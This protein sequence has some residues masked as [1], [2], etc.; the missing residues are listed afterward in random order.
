MTLGEKIFQLRKQM[1]LSQEQL[2]S[3]VTVSRQ[4]VSKWE[5][6]EAMPDVDNVVQLSRIFSVSTDYLLTDGDAAGSSMSVKIED[7]GSDTSLKTNAVGTKCDNQVTVKRRK[8]IPI[9][10]LILGGITTVLGMCGILITWIASM[11]HPVVYSISTVI[12]ATGGDLVKEAVYVGLRAFLLE[13]NAMGFFVFC[14][15]VAGVGLIILSVGFYKYIKTRH[16][17]E[18]MKLTDKEILGGLCG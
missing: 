7:A 17:K 18:E 14:C 6:N 1:G 16:G 2:A 3:Q 9:I 11:T 8:T 4:A 5:L 13:Y 15:A 12:A 10:F